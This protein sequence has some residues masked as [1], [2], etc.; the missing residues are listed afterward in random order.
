[1]ITHR[2][3]RLNAINMHVAEQGEGPLILLLHGLP[4][5]W[6]SWRRRND[7]LSAVGH[8]VVAPDQYSIF[9]LNGHANAKR[10]RRP[11]RSGKACGICRKARA[12]G[13]TGPVAKAAI[14]EGE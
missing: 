1:L 5:T 14:K 13:Q 12:Q 6:Y 2:H 9:H 3:T 7:A 4:E 11:S 8:R 10:G